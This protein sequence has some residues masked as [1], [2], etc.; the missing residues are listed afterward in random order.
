MGGNIRSVKNSNVRRNKGS[1]GKD[2]GAKGQKKSNFNLRTRPLAK[3]YFPTAKAI[4]G[5]E[6]FDVIEAVSEVAVE[7][8]TKGKTVHFRLLGHADTRKYD[9]NTQL[10]SDRAKAVKNELKKRVQDKFEGELWKVLNL[11]VKIDPRGTKDATNSPKMWAEDRRVDII[12]QS[13]SYNEPAPGTAVWDPYRHNGKFYRNLIF[14]D[15]DYNPLHFLWATHTY[16]LVEQY[17][18]R[19]LSSGGPGGSA[20]LALNLPSDEKKILDLF[21][22][23]V[24]KNKMSESD[25]QRILTRIQ[26]MSPSEKQKELAISWET[27]Y[28]KEYPEVYKRAEADFQKTKFRW[29][30]QF[31]AKRYQLVPKNIYHEKRR[32]GFPPGHWT[33]GI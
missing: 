22:D 23:L 17:E 5:F 21:R 8:I 33:E 6:D 3:I 27:E 1:M 29:R 26:G 32:K 25:Y 24:M 13:E 14:L 28:R 9:N 12:D 19:D 18:W 31:F 15:P 30:W 20:T 7:G 11:E 4:L 10:S 16:R 2:Y